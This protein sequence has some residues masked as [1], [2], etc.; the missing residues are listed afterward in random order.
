MIIGTVGALGVRWVAVVYITLFL[1]WV[2]L[3]RLLH[4]H[5]RLQ[6]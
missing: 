5:A 4:A 1:S 3:G 2:I 6:P